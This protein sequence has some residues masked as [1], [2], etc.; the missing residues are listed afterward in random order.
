MATIFSFPHSDDSSSSFFNI[1]S[2]YPGFEGEDGDE[3][4]AS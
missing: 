3:A 4:A 2:I 1:E